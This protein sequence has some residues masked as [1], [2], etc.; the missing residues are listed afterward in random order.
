MEKG[1]HALLDFLRTPPT[2]TPWGL[3]NFKMK[4]AEG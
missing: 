3:W 1:W 4:N 2:P